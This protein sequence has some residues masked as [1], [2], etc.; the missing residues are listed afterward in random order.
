[1]RK[2]EKEEADGSDRG[3]S[4]PASTHP[5]RLMGM[6]AKVKYSGGGPSSG[7]SHGVVLVRARTQPPLCKGPKHTGG[8]MPDLH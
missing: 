8:K 1:M 2:K 7:I 4:Q 5:M 6:S 3:N